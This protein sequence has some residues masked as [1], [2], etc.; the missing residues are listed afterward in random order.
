V[1]AD[2]EGISHSTKFV[3]IDKDARIRGYYDSGED[4]TVATILR[5][6]AGLAK[7]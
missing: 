6:A 2:S 3:L 1:E 4:S 5:D 7:E